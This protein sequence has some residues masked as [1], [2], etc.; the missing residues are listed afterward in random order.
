M[1]FDLNLSEINLNNLRERDD[2]IPP[3]CEPRPTLEDNLNNSRERDDPIPP[4][5]EPRPTLEDMQAGTE[6]EPTVEPG[7]MPVDEIFLHYGQHKEEIFLCYYSTLLYQ[8]Y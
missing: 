7:F 1:D 4:G 3:G 5:C 8:I 2:P 6:P